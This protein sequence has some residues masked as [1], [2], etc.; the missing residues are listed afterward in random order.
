MT[1]RDIPHKPAPGADELLRLVEEN[2]ADFRIDFSS[3]LALNPH[4][5]REFERRSLQVARRRSH[6]S[7][8]TIVEVMRHDTAIG[9]LSGDFK[10]NG[11]FVPCMARLF[12]LRWPAYAGLFEFRAPRGVAA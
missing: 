10:I 6:Y 12:A 1:D 4:I 3:W 5:Y 7:A 11:N 9:E 2:A 8:R